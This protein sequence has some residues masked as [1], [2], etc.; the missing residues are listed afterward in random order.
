VVEDENNTPIRIEDLYPGQIAEWYAEAEKNLERYV[1]ILRQIH[2]R[3]KAEGK[4]WPDLD[5]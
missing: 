1:E 5:S 4:N 3:L 2:S